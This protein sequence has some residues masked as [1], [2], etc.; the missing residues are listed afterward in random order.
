MDASYVGRYM[1]ALVDL[2]IYIVGPPP[3]N[4][5]ITVDTLRAG[6]VYPI[7]VYGIENLSGSNFARFKVAND[8]M[9]PYNGA[10]YTWIKFN[11]NQVGPPLPTNH[12]PIPQAP[13]ITDTIFSGAKK[14][15]WIGGGLYVLGQFLGSRK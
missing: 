7:A 1:Q 5:F 3:G 6:E 12:A 13:G 4:N 10:N 15:L 11:N 14:L 9:A 2:P 8:I